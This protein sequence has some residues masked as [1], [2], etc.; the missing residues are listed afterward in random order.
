MYIYICI[1]NSDPTPPTGAGRT[2]TQKGRAPIS[3]KPRQEILQWIYVCMYVCMYMHI[4]MYIYIYVR[5]GINIGNYNKQWENMNN[6]RR[7][8]KHFLKVFIYEYYS[9]KIKPLFHS[10]FSGWFLDFP[11]RIRVLNIAVTVANVFFP[12]LTYIHIYIYMLL[13]KVL[14]QIPQ[15]LLMTPDI[16]TQNKSH[17]LFPHKDT[18]PLKDYWAHQAPSAI[19]PWGSSYIWPLILQLPQKASFL[20]RFTRITHTHIYIY[21]YTYYRFLMGFLTSNNLP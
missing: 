16:V 6:I 14:V 1:F 2:P 5:D 12:S 20:R 11:C 18:W 15:K 8:I 19:C 4:H 9:A 3:H 7:Y 17:P 13:K 10:V 21:I